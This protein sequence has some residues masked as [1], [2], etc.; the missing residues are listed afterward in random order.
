MSN[1]VGREIL[2]VMQEGA[3]TR[4]IQSAFMN[5]GFWVTHITDL[6]SILDLLENKFFVAA[7]LEL[8]TPKT[9]YGLKLFQKIKE[10]SPLTATY[11]LSSHPDF[12]SLLSGHRMGVKDFIHTEGD[13]LPYLAGSV[14]KSASEIEHAGDRDRLLREMGHLHQKF[15]KQMISLHI[16]L[17]ENEE[18][19]RYRD[20]VPDEELPP[21]HILIV[22]PD[23]QITD[24]LRERLPEST[25]WTFTHLAWGGEALDYGSKGGF[26]LAFISRNLP[27]LPGTMVQQTIKADAADSLVFLFDRDEMEPGSMRLFENSVSQEIP[28]HIPNLDEL[29]GRLRDLRKNLDSAQ[30]KK[31]HLK[32]FKAQHYDFLQEYQRVQSKLKRVTQ[33]DE[34]PE[35]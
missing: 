14:R 23:Q 12:D 13:F 11:L 17:M 28:V 7:L 20:G 24:Q 9:G 34:K 15:L 16:K 5:L 25:G 22:D 32:T 21:C 1:Y 6:K 2:L 31:E 10:V 26:H 8:D 33:E 18:A 3:V 27:D 35:N 19:F 4:S 30:K 29:V